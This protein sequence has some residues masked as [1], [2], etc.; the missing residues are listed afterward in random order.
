MA[1]DAEDALPELYEAR[2]EL[3]AAG[4]RPY[5][6]ALIV[7]WYDAGEWAG[8]DKLAITEA[9][10][11]SPKVRRVKDQAVPVG[12]QQPDVWDIGPVTPYGSNLDVLEILLSAAEEGETRT[13][14]LTGPECPEGKR[15]RVLSIT[16][17]K[18]LRRMIRVQSEA[19][20]MQGLGGAI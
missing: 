1:T 10:G 20:A 13:L 2:S 7:D 19:E 17:D 14:L 18:P 6:V 11:Q 3:G 9:D 8:P 12:S 16:T 15:Y 4:F 5:T